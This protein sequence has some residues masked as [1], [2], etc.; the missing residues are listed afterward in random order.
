MQSEN[1]DGFVF[2]ERRDLIYVNFLN[3]AWKS[4]PMV[5]HQT[6]DKKNI[7]FDKKSLAFFNSDFK[8]QLS[9]CDRA[10]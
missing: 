7:L 9:Y 10:I 2:V 4:F 1:V 8:A 6:T 3:L 5:F